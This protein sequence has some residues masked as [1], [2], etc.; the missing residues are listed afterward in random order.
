MEILLIIIGAIIG[1]AIIWNITRKH[2][3]EIMI[4]KVAFEKR[5]VAFI[6]VLGFKSVVNKAESDQKD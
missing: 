1:G 6:D 4:E 3:G 5:A 2:S